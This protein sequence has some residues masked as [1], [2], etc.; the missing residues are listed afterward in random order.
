[1]SVTPGGR[2]TQDLETRDVSGLVGGVFAL[3]PVAGPGPMPAATLVAAIAW[4]DPARTHGPFVPD[5]DAAEPQVRDRSVAPLAGTASVSGRVIE[6]GGSAQPVRRARVT[7]RAADSRTEYAV[8]TDDEG[9]FV[10]ASLPPG[11]YSLVATK[12]AFLPSFYGSKRAGAGPGTPLALTGGRSTDELTLPLT[13]GAVISGRVTDDNGEPYP[14]ATVRVLPYSAGGSA[15]A[16]LER[17]IGG[18]IIGQGLIR[19]DDLGRYRVF[20]L[21]PGQYSVMASPLGQGGTEIRQLSRSDV[22]A[23][24]ADIERLGAGAPPPSVSASASSGVAGGGANANV[25]LPVPLGG[26]AVGFAPVYYPGTTVASEARP[27]TVAAGQELENIDMPVQLVPVARIEGTIAGP[28]G[29]PL[30]GVTAL[31]LPEGDSPVMLIGMT[32]IIRTRPDGTFSAANVAPGRYTLAARYDGGRGA[33]RMM[34]IGGGG[35]F[36]A[37]ED[38]TARPPAGEREPEGPAPKPLWAQATLDVNGQDI[39]GVAL[40]LQEGM[41]VSGRIVFAGERAAPADLTAVRINLLPIARGGLAIGLA[42][43]TADADGGFQLAGAA[44]GEYRL[45]ATLPG[46]GFS[47]DSGWQLQSAISGGRDV[48]DTN[49]VVE[50]GRAVD[51]LVL[52]FTDRR[53]ELSGTVTDPAGEP[54]SD[55]TILVFPTERAFWSADSRRMP[56]PQ[57]PGSDG[58]FSVD[59]LP[60]GEYYLAAV[61]QLEPENWGDPNFMDQLAAASIRI[62]LAEGEK[63]VQDI[64]IGG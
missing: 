39:S 47:A 43:T 22:D 32:S 50:P 57:Q 6:A 2:H 1:V 33:T 54:V 17:A 8:M 27:V 55:L 4:D 21:A 25:P 63:K 24:V 28:D 30:P 61:T 44:P 11:R 37:R 5:V 49:L 38:M 41:A 62:T 18:G 7:M 52:T 35:V 31:L 34:D 46:S 53:T 20:G 42:G 26:R 9:R 45:A 48:L 29:R 59:G 12:P 16:G 64:R 40:T 15:R 36:V 23:V 58:R 10:L 51:D 14:G 3:L 13:R 56:R 60:P 19:T